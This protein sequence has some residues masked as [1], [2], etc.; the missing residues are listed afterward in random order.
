VN[1][2]RSDNDVRF[3]GQI[4]DDE[5]GL[6][7]N[8]N[9][10]YSPL[11]GRYFQADP[12]GVQGGDYNIYRYA[13]GNPI[14]Y[15]DPY[16]LYSWGDFWYDA[17]QFA[18]GFG[19]D[20]SLGFS[21]WVRSWPLYGGDCFTNQSSAAY[22]LGEWMGVVASSYL[23]FDVGRLASLA[24][25]AEYARLGSAGSGRV[26]SHW[27]PARYL[28]KFGFNRLA[29]KRTIWNGNFISRSQ[30]LNYDPHAQSKV[31]FPPLDGHLVKT[32]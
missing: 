27:I 13:N 20:V 1:S 15:I 11:L 16:G 9:R 17:G 22:K 28:R 12:L 23:G 8:W 21:K 24:R 32:L 4:C 6:Y 3:P 2:P 31:T 7:Y 19:D 10:Y 18:V 14:M 29:D 25:A 30:H 26:F 5:T